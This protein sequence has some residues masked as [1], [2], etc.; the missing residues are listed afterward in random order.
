MTGIIFFCFIV[1][2]TPALVHAETA[3]PD[4]IKPAEVKV[5]PLN[6]QVDIPGLKPEDLTIIGSS[7]NSE[8]NEG[9]ICAYTI[10]AY[11][12]ALYTWAAA[13]AVTFAIVLIMIGGAQYAVGAATGSTE[14]GLKRMRNAAMGL[15]I[16]LGV[17][18][19]LGFVNPQILTF[20]PLKLEIVDPLAYVASSLDVS[21]SD[22]R[23]GNALTIPPGGVPAFAGTGKGAQRE[24]FEKMGV[25]CPGSGGSTE[26]R[27]VAESLMGKVNYRLGGKLGLTAPYRWELPPNK[28]PARR[29]PEGDFY[30][31]FCPDD[32]FCLDCSGFAQVVAECAGLASR[33]DSGGTAQIFQNA[34]RIASCDDDTVSLEDG[35]ERDL[36]PG[37]YVGFGPQHTPDGFGH[38]WMYIGNGQLANSSGSG[39]SGNRGANIR[40]LDWA[41]ANFPLYL[42]AVGT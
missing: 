5:L 10:G 36:V 26:V 24:D 34:P 33:G 18:A 1:L 8:C 27:K 11:A 38:V 7:D 6:L 12:N 4:E 9:F 23:L 41:C 19:I 31:Y 22:A 28:V 40:A 32:S 17:S 15:I 30:G 21:L 13:A 42:R 39:R 3:T 2:A 16:V 20:V 25:Y 35:S 14:P 37:D 29:S